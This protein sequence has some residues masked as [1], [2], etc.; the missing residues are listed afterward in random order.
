[1]SSA[2]ASLLMVLGLWLSLGLFCCSG[3][4]RSG[5]SKTLTPAQKAEAQSDKN[6]ACNTVSRLQCA[7]A[8][9][10]VEAGYSGVTHAYVD[11]GFFSIAV[12]AKESAMK[13]VALCHISLE[14]K[15]QIGLVV[16]HNG[17][18]GKKIGTY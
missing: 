16:I 2:I 6:K 3:S 8:F 11:Q 4:S 7:G 15:D 5:D 12:D 14:K 18:S 9:T 17:Y 10:K 1:M 13:A